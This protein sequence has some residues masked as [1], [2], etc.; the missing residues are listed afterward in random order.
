[1][2]LDLSS[3]KF[4]DTKFMTAEEKAKTL[5]DWERFLRRGLL[6]RNFSKRLYKHLTL[7]CSFIA[8]YSREGFH[9]HYFRDPAMTQKFLGQFDGSRGG[10]SVEMGAAYWLTDQRY[11]DINSAMCDVAGVYAPALRRW[12]EKG[13]RERDLAIANKL[14]AKWEGV[15]IATEPVQLTLTL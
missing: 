1:V 13:E 11:A 12:A 4:S 2:P 9:G 7:H 5:R 8:H 3:Y 14:L 6:F 10:R 15:P